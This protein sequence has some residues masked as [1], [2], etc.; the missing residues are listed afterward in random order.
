MFSENSNAEFFQQRIE[1]YL[2]AASSGDAEAQFQL[3]S[4]YHFGIGP[5]P[6]MVEATKWYQK[7]MAQGHRPAFKQIFN[8]NASS[9][10]A[11]P[12]FAAHSSTLSLTQ[13]FSPAREKMKQFIGMENVKDQLDSYF[14]I[15]RHNEMRA[16]YGLPPSEAKINLV[17]TG[18][19]GTGKTTT[20]RVV[21]EVLKEAGIL[22]RGHV[23]ETSPG[24]ICDTVSTAGSEVR[25]MK[26][27]IKDARGGVLFIDEA[28]NFVSHVAKGSEYWRNAITTLQTEMTSSKKDQ[29]FAVILA[30][31]EDGINDLFSKEPGLKSRFPETIHFNDYN[32][33]ELAEIFA[34]KAE[35]SAYNLAEGCKEYLEKNIKEGQNK[36]AKNFGNARYVENLFDKTIRCIANRTSKLPFATKEDMTSINAFDIRAAHEA[37]SKSKHQT[38]ILK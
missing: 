29:K 24:A 7:A 18:N 3:A 6:N 10:T 22:S 20:A 5:Q 9:M 2:K 34:L 1:A 32:T 11:Q 28:H 31:Y 12:Q 36:Y 26:Q 14:N 8:L 15:F 23:V 13:P 25:E 35:T 17:F 19:P 33:S 38:I 30:G 4:Y 21:G 27:K 37:L 16:A